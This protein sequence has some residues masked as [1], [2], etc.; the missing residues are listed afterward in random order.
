MLP[1]SYGPTKKPSYKPIGSKLGLFFDPED[2][3]DIF[4]RKVG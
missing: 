2:G 3:G 4:L 1:P